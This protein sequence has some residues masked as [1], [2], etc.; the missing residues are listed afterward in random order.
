VTRPSFLPSY[1]T[2]AARRRPAVDWFLHGLARAGCRIVEP[3][4]LGIAP[5]W[6]VVEVPGAGCLKL[7]AYVC[8][9]TSRETKNRPVDEARFQL[10]F[11]PRID[12]ELHQLP[13]EPSV[14]T[15]LLGI[16]TEYG[17]GVSADPLQHNPTRF[18]I[19]IEYKK[20]HITAVTASGWHAWER[21]RRG[22]N[23]IADEESALTETLVGFR[24]ERSLDLLLFERQARGAP[25]EYRHLLADSWPQMTVAGPRQ[26][27][28]R[29][30]HSLLA[31]LDMSAEEVMDMIAAA[32][33]LLMAV[34]GW[35]AQHHLGKQL[36]RLGCV[37]A[38]EPIEQDGQ[39]DFRLEIAGRYPKSVVLVECKNTLRAT[40]SAGRP[41]L[42]FQR[43]RAPQG[44]PCGRYYTP[45]EFD[46]LAACMHPTTERWE[47]LYHATAH[48]AS[49]PICQGRLNHRV[50]VAEPGWSSDLAEVLGQL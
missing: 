31:L 3:P 48:M 17:I 49:H 10:K 33:R 37:R 4:D 24:Q 1:P 30:T 2:V 9:A 16:D 26:L 21:E 44:N 13:D 39:P 19:S 20:A 41:R 11:G 35:T 46:I 38:V 18:Y 28:S 47:F 29:S 15:L 40:D 27:L 43:T 6:A 25:P 34:R 12:G 7:A 42:D 50:V 8:T 23:L 45:D 22:G 5:F 32:P 36:A 14:T